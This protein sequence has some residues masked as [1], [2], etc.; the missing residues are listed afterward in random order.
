MT[1]SC[2]TTATELMSRERGDFEAN[3]WLFRP[4]PCLPVCDGT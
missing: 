2:F 3:P 1:R 4:V